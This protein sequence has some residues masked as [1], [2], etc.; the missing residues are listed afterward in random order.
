LTS[1]RAIPSLLIGPHPRARPVAA[2]VFQLVKE[3]KVAVSS[4]ALMHIH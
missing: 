1:H 3:A 4:S 2:P